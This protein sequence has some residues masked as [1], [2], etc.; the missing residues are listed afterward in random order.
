MSDLQTMVMEIRMMERPQL[1][2]NLANEV[3]EPERH[4][5][6]IGQGAVIEKM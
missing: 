2:L 4:Q 5:Q 3:F 1:D 6:Q